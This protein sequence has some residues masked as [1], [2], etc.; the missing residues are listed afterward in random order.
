VEIV[1]KVASQPM[2]WV[3]HLD[4]KAF[5]QAIR[6]HTLEHHHQLQRT[7]ATLLPAG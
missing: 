6:V 5:V 3:E 1:V 2:H 7:L 4:W